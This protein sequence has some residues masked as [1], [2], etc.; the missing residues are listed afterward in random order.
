MTREEAIARIKALR[1][2]AADEASSEAEAAAAAARASKII[3]Q[4]EVTEEELIERGVGGVTEA[5]HNAGRRYAHPTLEE[6][7]G[8]IGMY[9]ECSALFRRGANLWVGQPED[10][11][12]ALYLCEMI[13]AAAERAYLNHRKARFFSAPNAHYRR[14]FLIG[15]GRSIAERLWNMTSE[16]RRSRARKGGGTDLIVVKNALI[17]AYMTENYPDIGHTRSRARKEPDHRAFLS[18]YVDAAR[19]NLERPLCGTPAA[20][21]IGNA[22]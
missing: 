5:E 13:Q 21:K 14:S 15:F 18:G 2:R 11:E 7:A 1:A 20:G 3:F 12:F 9:A 6:A 22:A 16:R 10:V 8:A 19:V 17:D 4:F